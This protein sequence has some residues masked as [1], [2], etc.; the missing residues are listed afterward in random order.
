[1][2]ALLVFIFCILKCSKSAHPLATMPKHVDFLQHDG[3]YSMRLERKVSTNTDDYNGKYR[4]RGSNSRVMQRNDYNIQYVG[5]LYMGDNMQKVMVVWDSGSEW[6][7]V[8]SNKCSTCKT[9]GYDTTTS[10]S[11]SKI[12]GSEGDQLYGSA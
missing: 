9:I 7:V 3:G 5:P 12:V 8:D 11:F 2:K 10:P 1:M 4:L 6:L